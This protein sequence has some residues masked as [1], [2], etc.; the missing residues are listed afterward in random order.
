[1]HRPKM[2]STSIFMTTELPAQLPSTATLLESPPAAPDATDSLT[3]RLPPGLRAPVKLLHDSAGIDT[4]SATVATACLLTA[5]AGDNLHVRGAGL[6]LRVAGSLLM[7]LPPTVEPARVDQILFD[8]L[9]ARDQQVQAVLR[10]RAR[11]SAPFGIKAETQKCYSLLRDPS[12]GALQLAESFNGYNQLLVTLSGAE[13]Y[14]KATIN[15]FFDGQS[16][17]T[18]LCMAWSRR[19]RMVRPRYSRSQHLTPGEIMVCFIAIAPAHLVR[20]SAVAT[21]ER[22]LLR[23][24]LLRQAPRF[25]A[26]PRPADAA[27]L[28]VTSEDTRAWEDTL[29]RVTRQRLAGTAELVPDEKSKAAFTAWETRITGELSALKDTDACELGVMRSLPYRLY[30]GLQ[31][32][33]TR[34]SDDTRESADLALELAAT[35]WQRTTTMFA[36]AAKDND[37]AWLDAHAERLLGKLM[38][39]GPMT[40]RELMRRESVQRFDYHEPALRMLCDSHR[41]AINQGRY[42]AITPASVDL[43]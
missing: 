9:P 6:S 2:I 33:R 21:R 36:A 35:I 41:I 12:I 20:G 30:A 39:F 37:E 8:G 38:D 5:W 42:A 22:D 16:L 18:M 3:P 28:G 25:C 26:F 13:W 29:D 23:R 7:G 17:Q 34:S 14:H 24:S 11:G 43:N 27:L 4:V 31:L 10:E 40:P 32:A 15:N 1:M 19:S